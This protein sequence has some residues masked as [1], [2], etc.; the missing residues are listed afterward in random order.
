M[1]TINYDHSKN[2]HLLDGPEVVF[3]IIQEKFNPVSLLDVGCGLGTWLQVA[4]KHGVLDYYGIDGIENSSESFYASKH[5]FSQYDLRQR[6]DL[7]RR[8]DIVFCLE[9]A[10]HLDENVSDVL[11][12]CLVNHSDTIIFS[13]ACPHQWGQ[14]HVNCQWPEYWQKKF[15][16]HGFVCHDSLRSIIWNRPFPEYWYKQNIF[17]A[18]KN[19]ERAGSEE[20]LISMIHPDNYKGYVMQLSKLK[21]HHQSLVDGMSSFRIYFDLLLK[22]IKPSLKRKISKV[23]G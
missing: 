14:G 12:S 17:V 8:F 20:R 7:N 4:E 10:E 22:S 5:K 3:P 13:A 16:Q 18:Q 15:N 1:D 23:I 6:W 11:V 2:Q 9:V 19:I 21:K